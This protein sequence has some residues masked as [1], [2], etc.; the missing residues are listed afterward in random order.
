MILVSP[1]LL[2][3]LMRHCRVVLQLTPESWANTR[4]SDNRRMLGAELRQ[5]DKILL[6]NGYDKDKLKKI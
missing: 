2:I 1:R 5:L 4:L 6:R 3:R